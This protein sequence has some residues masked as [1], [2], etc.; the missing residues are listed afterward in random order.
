MRQQGST[1][2]TEFSGDWHWAGTGTDS[3][4]DAMYINDTQ[5]CYWTTM[6]LNKIGSNSV[7]VL[8]TFQK[9]VFTI[10]PK[11]P[12]TF[13]MH[14]MTK[15]QTPS[16]STFTDTSSENIAGL[17]KLNCACIRPLV[18][19]W[20]PHVGIRKNK[21]YKKKFMQDTV[22]PLP[23]SVDYSK[24]DNLIWCKLVSYISGPAPARQQYR[25]LP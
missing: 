5:H 23:F 10:I 8:Q 20:H 2:A 18:Q 3:S 12:G 13:T 9:W 1:V 21:N 17:V 24:L 6:I 19:S 14:A 22:R 25:N 7:L 4:Q 16:W 15:L 11:M